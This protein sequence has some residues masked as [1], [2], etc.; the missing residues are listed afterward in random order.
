MLPGRHSYRRA[1]KPLM[2][3]RQVKRVMLTVEAAP[4]GDRLQQ[5]VGWR[6]VLSQ[7]TIALEVGCSVKAVKRNLRRCQEARPYRH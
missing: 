2:L 3:A 5:E 1:T 6:L 4:D 7:N